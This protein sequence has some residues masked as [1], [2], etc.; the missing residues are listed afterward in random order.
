M[1]EPRDKRRTRKTGPPEPAVQTVT[2]T[3][4]EPQWTRGPRPLLPPLKVG[5]EWDRVRRIAYL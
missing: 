3:A 1:T 5:R 4:E 2:E